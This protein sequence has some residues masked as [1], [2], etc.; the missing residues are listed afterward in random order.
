MEVYGM[1]FIRF[2]TIRSFL[3]INTSL[4]KTININTCTKK[5]LQSHPCIAYKLVS[6]IINY[7]HQYGVYKTLS[8]LTKIHLI[9][10]L[11]FRKIAPYLTTDENKSVSR[12]Y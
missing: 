9:D 10:S 6:A 3:E 7:K 12:T 2:E 8:D 11:K 5:E 1:D 4:T